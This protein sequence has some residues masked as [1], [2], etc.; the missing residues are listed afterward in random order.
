MK[1]SYSKILI[2]VLS[3]VPK[4]WK[5][6]IHKRRQVSRLATRLDDIALW[7]ILEAA[8]IFLI[9]ISGVSLLYMAGTEPEVL[10]F[11][12]RYAP[13]AFAPWHV[14]ISIPPS[15]NKEPYE[16]TVTIPPTLFLIS[17][18]KKVDHTVSQITLNTDGKHQNVYELEFMVYAGID[19]ISYVRANSPFHS[20]SVVVVPRDGPIVFRQKGM[21]WNLIN[22]SAFPFPDIIAEVN[23]QQEGQFSLPPFGSVE[24]STP[25]VGEWVLRNENIILARHMIS[26]LSIMSSSNY[27]ESKNKKST[28]AKIL[29]PIEKESI[30]SKVKIYSKI[31]DCK[32]L[33]ADFCEVHV[34]IPQEEIPEIIRS[35]RVSIPVIIYTQDSQNQ[36]HEKSGTIFPY[37]EFPLSSFAELWWY[38]PQ[39]DQ[40]GR[41]E[42][43]P[44]IGKTTEAYI[45]WTLTSIP[46]KDSPWNITARLSSPWVFG[47][48]PLRVSPDSEI[49]YDRISDLI[50]WKGRRVPPGSGYSIAGPVVW[51]PVTLTPRT[52][53]PARIPVL[54]IISEN[55]SDSETLFVNARIPAREN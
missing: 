39:G 51:I 21:K 24:I 53:L 36:L 33:Q 31:V 49:T 47:N 16:V 29:I 4:W 2:S 55:E 43:P 26:E 10:R 34:T 38:T 17:P 41:G 8:G 27:I 9:V 42:W 5:E 11:T 44:K 45:V 50:V 15:P 7:V 23:G 25:R 46:G 22:Y 28:T 20:A 40:V 48:L 19:S 3:Y 12:S 13:S 18:D 1:K 52:P 6:R 35:R 30:Q 37:I 14:R 54:S 32:I